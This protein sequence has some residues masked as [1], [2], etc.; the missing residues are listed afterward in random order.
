M[1]HNVNKKTIK[2]QFIKTLEPPQV[3]QVR[4][5]EVLTKDNLFAQITVRFLT[6]QVIN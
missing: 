6:Q 2:W 4:K 5:M 3:M 1:M